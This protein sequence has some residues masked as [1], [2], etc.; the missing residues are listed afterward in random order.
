MA[1]ERLLC[2]SAWLG[3]LPPILPATESPFLPVGINPESADSPP[4]DPRHEATDTSP[5]RSKNTPLTASVLAATN[6][7]PDPP[8]PTPLTPPP[9]RGKRHKK[10]PAQARRQQDQPRAT[11]LPNGRLRARKRIARRSTPRPA[12]QNPA[13][14]SPR[15]TNL[16]FRINCPP[17]SAPASRSGRSK[18]KTKNHHPRT[19]PRHRQ[20]S[21]TSPSQ[22]SLPTL[23]RPTTP[24][25]PRALDLQHKYKVVALRRTLRPS[26]PASRFPSRPNNPPTPANR[27]SRCP[28]PTRSPTRT[29]H[30]HRKR[31]HLNHH[32]RP[33]NP[34]PH[35]CRHLAVR[36]Q[37]PLAGGR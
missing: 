11:K 25:C 18:P 30:H 13:A 20:T 37:C 29:T 7:P 35:P 10:S 15:P 31:Q 4:P 33:R 3:F 12:Q 28:N 17:H 24:P 6:Q 2:C 16:S 1:R 27:R 23:K 26:R 36:H 9:R 14:L 22:P 34:F 8:A 32:S 21:R 5:A 19:H